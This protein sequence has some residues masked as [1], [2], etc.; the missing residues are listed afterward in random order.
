MYCHDL[1]VMSFNPGGIKLGVRSRPTYVLKS[2]LNQNIIIE[3]VIVNYR[4]AVII[5]PFPLDI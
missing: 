1:E 2:Y 3:I 4:N 5:I